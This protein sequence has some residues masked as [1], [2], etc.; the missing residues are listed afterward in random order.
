M[1][2]K[3]SRARK[4]NVGQENDGRGER[5]GHSHSPVDEGGHE[6]DVSATA[7]A[8][9]KYRGT[10]KIAK[11]TAGKKVHSTKVKALGKLGRQYHRRFPSTFSLNKWQAN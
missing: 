10:S 5:R 1:N 11:S 6:R 2:H 4:E 8:I 9:R 7:L 3:R